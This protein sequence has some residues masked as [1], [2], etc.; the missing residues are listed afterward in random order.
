MIVITKEQIEA[1]RNGSYTAFEQ[2]LLEKL[3]ERYPERIKACGEAPA[4]GMVRLGVERA[5]SRGLA[6][7]EDLLRYLSMMLLFGSEWEQDPQLPWA[8]NALAEND[9]P[10]PARMARLWERA[11]AAQARVMGADDG[12]YRA[13]LRS[14]A[15]KSVE[16]VAKLASRSQRDLADQL[17]AMWPARFGDTGES[18]YREL[19]RRAVDACRPFDLVDRWSVVL[20]VEL[21]LLFGTGFLSDP[22]HEWAHAALKD[23]QAGVDQKLARLL[24]GAQQRIPA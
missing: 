24:E 20:M 19:T 11:L 12:L 17:A 9:T 14:L 15:G 21:M 7:E 6:A 1:F 22:L 8:T 10:A 18:V 23:P 3:A 5:K 4:L 13:A 16:D 2:R